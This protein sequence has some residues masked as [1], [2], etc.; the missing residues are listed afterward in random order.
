M[1]TDEYTLRGESKVVGGIKI[2]RY[3]HS[4]KHRFGYFP[5]SIAVSAKESRACDAQYKHR[6]VR[7]FI[8]GDHFW[9]CETE[10]MP[11]FMINPDME[12]LRMS[13]ADTGKYL[14]EHSTVIGHLIKV[15]GR[16]CVRYT[17]E[18]IAA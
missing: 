10:E 4:Y 6:G 2:A 12:Q 5:G 18:R 13:Y 14:S 8:I 15:N 16:Y 3:A 11:V 17:Q 1:G 7:H 9:N